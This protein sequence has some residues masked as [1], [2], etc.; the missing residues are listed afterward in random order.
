MNFPE[1]VIQYRDITY[2]GREVIQT[3]TMNLIYKICLLTKL[4]YVCVQDIWHKEL[5]K[6]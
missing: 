5:G 1:M 3:I 4:L 2:K 6:Y